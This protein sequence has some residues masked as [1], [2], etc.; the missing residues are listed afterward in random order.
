MRR[1]LF[2]H[3]MMI[4]TQPKDLKSAAMSFSP[5]D[6]Q[7]EARVRASFARQR[8]METIG[9]TLTRVEPGVVEV[10]L[11]YRADL[12][13]QHGFLHAG[14]VATILDSA[15][16]YAAFSL[17]ACQRCSAN[18]RIQDQ[19]AETGARRSIRRESACGASWTDAY[20]LLGRCFRSDGSGRKVDRNN[21]RH[22]VR[23]ARARRS[24]AVAPR[25]SP[26]P[27]A[28]LTETPI[29]ASI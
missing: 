1:S 10:A 24:K 6:P 17:M 9:A 18:G 25:E 5:L 26:A 2:V 27:C 29:F 12:T 11:P 8:A 16:G 19:P 3:A 28:G 20:R 23:R 13:Q 22:G 4:V 15:C 14:I 7:F 21:A